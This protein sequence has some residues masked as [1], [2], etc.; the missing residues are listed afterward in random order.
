MNLNCHDKLA[1][2]SAQKAQGMFQHK[3][4]LLVL[5][6]FVSQVYFW[7]QKSSPPFHGEL[8]FVGT[9]IFPNDS[10]KE[11]M[12]IYA[13]DSLVKV[14]T[15][16]SNFGKQ[17][18]LKHLGVQKSYLMLS[19]TKGNYAVKTDYRSHVD[20]TYTFQKRFGSKKILGK[21]AKRAVV[22]FKN[23]EKSFDFYYYKHIPATYGSAFTN[24]PG[25]VVDYYLPSDQGLFHFQLS[26]L[27]KFDPPL[28]LFM[29]P[30]GYKR[31]SL[32][33]FLKE[34]QTP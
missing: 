15:F 23:L 26:E 3:M 32:D 8:L 5:L 34:M 25:L 2:L 9:K 20:S 27:R 4:P 1:I 33:D 17:E 18:L 29:L 6:I 31:I 22:K 12:L 7:G 19:T 10:T 24:F 13:K 21:R 11:E 16:S 28:T 30:E 14:V